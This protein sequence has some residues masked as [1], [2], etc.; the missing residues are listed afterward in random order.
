MTTII[1]RGIF[2]GFVMVLALFVGMTVPV[3]GHIAEW[4]LGP[5]YALPEAYWGV[6]HDPF[7]ILAAFVLNVVFYSLLACVVLLV[8]RKVAAQKI[9]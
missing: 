7:Q 8:K 1:V 4:A 9:T 6:A 2:I 5:G 3:V